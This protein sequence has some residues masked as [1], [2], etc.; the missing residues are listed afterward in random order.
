MWSSVYASGKYNKNFTYLQ[1]TRNRKSGGKS[2]LNYDNRFANVPVNYIPEVNV[3]NDSGDGATSVASSSAI[4][5]QKFF[6]DNS[7]SP[8]LFDRLED[9]NG[10]IYRIVAIEDYTRP[11]NSSVYYLH[12]RRDILTAN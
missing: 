5:P 6:T 8:S 1:L 10:L 4:V 11:A 2:N 12:L 7:I 9:D 3:L